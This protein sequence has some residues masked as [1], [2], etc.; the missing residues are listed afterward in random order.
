MFRKLLLRWNEQKN[1]R[2]MPWKGVKVAYNVWI[3]EVILQQTRVDQGEKYYHAL[4]EKYPT[5]RHLAE[6][7]ETE[8]YKIWQ[9]LGYYSRCKNMLHTAKEIVMTHGGKFPDSYHEIIRLKGIGSYT[10]AAIASFAYDLPHA[11]VDGNVVRV[12]SR[13]FG[14]TTDF[15]TTKGK[16]E[17]E[18]LAQELLD[19]K[20]SAAYN[21]AIMD[22]GATVCKPQK[23]LCPECPLHKKCVARIE[24]RI[25]EF[26]VKKSRIKIKERYFHFMIFETKD[27]L[28]IHKRLDKDIWQNLYCFYAIE[29]S[30]IEEADLSHF[31][32]KGILPKISDTHTQLLTH[33]KIHGSFYKIAI[34]SD[35]Q[36]KK[37]DLIKVKKTELKNFA[38]PR[39][40]ISF[41]EKNHYL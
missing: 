19:K 4:L 6:A 21:Q 28:F 9:G 26:P 2:K 7:D 11:V 32:Q 35:I 10:A 34:S 25:S 40:I 18:A 39:M 36:I 30:N 33:Q 15:Y 29:A 41:L 8:L 13:Y 17:Y 24:N 31:I 12:L 5:V 20:D 27:A 23:P 3:S 38:F 22:L 14:I 37:L 16:K 1:Q